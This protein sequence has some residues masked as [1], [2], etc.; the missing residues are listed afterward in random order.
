V[1]RIDLMGVCKTLKDPK[2]ASTFA[3]QNLSLRIPD[4]KTMVVLGP[5][6]C[7]KTTLLK[8]IAG[9]IAPDSG[10]VRYDDV[11]VK[12]VRPGDRRIGMIFQNYALYP[13]FTSRTNVLSYFLFRK[14][15]PD[16]DALARAK[17]SGP[18]S[19]W[20]S[21]FPIS[22]TA[23]PPRSPAA[24]SRESPWGAASPGTRHSS[25]WTSPLPTWTRRC[26]K[27]IAST[28]RS[29]CGSSTSRRCT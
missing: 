5:S 3:I 17:Y 19:S 21:S 6:G 22:W 18:A 10:D 28:S 8:I 1:A 23:S 12:D 24:K 15:T 9:L 29:C 2:A 27:N 4:G 11:D 25:W 13:H 7:G 20:G 16:L 14:K 26:G